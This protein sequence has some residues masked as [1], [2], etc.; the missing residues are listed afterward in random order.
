MTCLSDV[1]LISRETRRDIPIRYDIRP[2]HSHTL[3]HKT[4]AIFFGRITSQLIILAPPTELIDEEPVLR[5]ASRSLSP[6]P[7]GEGG[8]VEARH[9]EGTLWIPPGAHDIVLHLGYLVSDIAQQ[10]RHVQRDL[11]VDLRTTP[12]SR[13]GNVIPAHAVAEHHVE[14]RGGAAFFIVALD[15]DSV[16][17][18]PPEEKPLDL[19]R[20]AVIVDMD[21][22][23]GGEEAV[24]FVNGEGMRVHSLGL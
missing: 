2:S 24:E 13:L 20:V 9:V 5:C 11:G 3:L 8:V 19:V 23:I 1:N 12:D 6:G 21:W 4:T 14:G 10:G 22:A 18:L 7:M 15:A 16:Q 17:I